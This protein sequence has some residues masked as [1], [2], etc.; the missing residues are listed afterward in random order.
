M[1]KDKEKDKAKGTSKDAESLDSIKKKVRE[2]KGEVLILNAAV[3][4]LGLVMIIMPEQ[5]NQFVG[6]ILGVV[7]IV[8]GILRCISFIRLKNDEMF[9]SFA[10]V[11]GAAMLGFGAFFLFRP[12]DFKL[13]LN[14]ALILIILIVAVLKLQYAI[15]Y[16]KLKSSKWWIHLIVAVVLIAF[17]VFA[18]LK[19]GMPIE[20][21]IIKEASALNLLTRIIGIGFVISGIWD[22]IAFLFMSKIIKKSAETP[23]PPAE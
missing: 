9:G 11:Q 18:I 16:F 3:F 6:Q 23:A 5:F 10:L 17:G 15:N 14:T 4:L 13:L 19:P 21:G 12:E 7:L 1:A 20:N 2:M 8:W 22:T